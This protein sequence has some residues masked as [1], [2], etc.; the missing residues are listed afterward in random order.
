MAHLNLPEITPAL[1]AL[2]AA[3]AFVGYIIFGAT[4]FGSA[5]VS[6][7]LLAH[8]L[9]VAA[10]VPMICTLDTFAATS[11]AWRDRRLVAWPELRR[12]VPSMLVGIALG[13]TL[14][15]R[16]PAV[17]LLLAL[18]VFGT[19]YGCYVLSGAP[20]PVRTPGW[21]VWPIGVVG[22]IFS[23]LF[24]SGGPIY[25]IYLSARIHDKT[26]LR[27]AV[28]SVIALSVWLRI[29]LFVTAGVLLDTRLLQLIA[30]LVPV[31]LAGL[32]LGRR[33]HARL[34]NTGVLRLIAALLAANG[35]TLLGRALL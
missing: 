30:A 4:G 14:L 15:V 29:A 5:V 1:L 23:A 34:S 31:M 19:L 8:V 12:L 7:P 21:L 17:P 25:I 18:G 26:A 11:T 9:P 35:L 2:V 6:V 16:L 33:L 20:R 10:C 24:G 3:T 13:T 22:G 32:F 28:A 27:G